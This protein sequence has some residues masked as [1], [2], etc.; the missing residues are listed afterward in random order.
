MQF[1][2]V[3]R[4]RLDLQNPTQKRVA[5]TSRAHLFR[6]TSNVGN[7]FNGGVDCTVSR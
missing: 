4:R 5:V 7:H 3:S 2:A 1:I 6:R